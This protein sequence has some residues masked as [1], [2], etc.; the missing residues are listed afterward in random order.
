MKKR[1]LLILLILITIGGTTILLI[2]NRDDLTENSNSEIVVIEHF[3]I[4]SV[5]ADSLLVI[6]GIERIYSDTTFKFQLR[7]RNGHVTKGKLEDYLTKTDYGYILNIKNNSPV[8]T[9][10]IIETKIYVPGGFGSKQYY[11]FD[12]LNGELK[13][14]INLDDDG[15]SPAV[16]R[17][18][19]LIFNTESCTIFAINRFTGEMKW[20]YW[21]SDPLLSTPLI[22]ND[23]VYTSYPNTTLY[24][25]T[26]L[27]SKY[28][29]IKP[30]NPF[31]CIEASTGKIKWQKW[32]DGDILVTPVSDGEHI[33]FT[34]FPG[35][36]YK[37]N[38]ITGEII[39]SIALN[40]T[41]PPSIAD[42]K[43]FVTKR[44]DSNGVVNE[45]IAILNSQKLEFI[46]EYNTVE[47]LY[48]DYTIQ[49]KS[50]LK[51]ISQKLDANNGFTNGAPIT[52]G[53]KL[54]SK[55]IGQSNVSSLQLFQPSTVS[56]INGRAYNLMG[57]TIYC[58]DPLSEEVIWKYEIDG[59]LKTIGGTLATTP[60]FS[61]SCLIT[62]TVNGELIVLNLS[63]GKKILSKSLNETVRTSPIM[64]EGKIFVPTTSGKLFCVDTKNIAL[65]GWT[66]FMK[67][68]EHQIN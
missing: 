4:D 38:A 20:S 55:N 42:G 46:K 28:K 5:M 3:P 34:T 48:L 12:Y 1:Y 29:K 18:S 53:W 23:Y 15:P 68:N 2:Q 50:S 44:N 13:W 39:S 45:S 40:A 25:D 43:V 41:S 27:T 19:L 33:F 54:A 32:L 36:V 51:S 17:D 52:S 59:D 57:N 26:A 10:T 16:Q 47:A 6:D 7:I 22:V 61:K 11:A 24:V 65:D 67:N 8:S 9:P 31:V 21:L 14:A 63:D 64:K 60:I 35:T 37:L 56:F 30:T 49:S 62:V 58:T 66:M